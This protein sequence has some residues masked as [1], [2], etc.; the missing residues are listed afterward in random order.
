MGKND[1]NK[2]TRS[3]ADHEAP[4][5]PDANCA[6]LAQM[7][8]ML[9]E[10]RTELISRFENTIS[11]VIKREI[12]AAVS[13]LEAKMA[14]FGT[15]IHGLEHAATDQD[16]RLTSLQASVSKLNAL[17]ASL[18]QKCED[19]ESRSR[20]NNVRLVGVPEALEGSQP[21]EFVASLLQDLLGLAAKPVLDRAHRTLRARPAE[22][23]PPRPFVIRVN[24][25][26]A[27]NE[28]LRKARESSPLIYKGKQVFIFPDFTTAVAKKRATF[29][30]VKKELR[31]C[32]GI[33]FGL[34]F[35]ATLRITLSDGTIRK[36]DDPA[37]AGDF[38]EKNLKN[39]V[40][41]DFVWLKK[42][43]WLLNDWTAL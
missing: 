41:P 23:E 35:P 8:Q 7:K 11:D 27:R 17:A 43:Q 34:L 30:K 1:S 6:L 36:F 9:D 39:A 20:L 13:P 31:S 25:L 14:S 33:R 3:R 10:S 42:C 18:A 28:I 32:P 12:S 22:G 24:L 2:T 5:E 38:V 19:L 26:Q 4:A 15:V 37:L 21:T 29:T 16:G 40:A